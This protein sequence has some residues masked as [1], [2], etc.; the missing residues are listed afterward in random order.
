MKAGELE[1]ARAKKKKVLNGTKHPVTCLA[2][3]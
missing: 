1:I 2:Y 3:V